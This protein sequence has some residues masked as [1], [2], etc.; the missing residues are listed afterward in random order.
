MRPGQL[1]RVYALPTPTGSKHYGPTIPGS[2]TASVRRYSCGDVVNRRAGGW[3]APG[4]IKHRQPSMG[5]SATLIDAHT[6][7][8]IWKSDTPA[9]GAEPGDFHRRT[10][11]RCLAVD[12]D[13][14][15]AICRSEFFKGAVVSAP[16][17]DLQTAP[18]K[19]AVFF[20][21]VWPPELQ[22]GRRI[23]P[24]LEA[25]GENLV[26]AATTGATAAAVFSAL[27]NGSRLRIPEL[28]WS[29]I[30]TGVTATP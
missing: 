30:G 10:V 21:I 20:L 6:G 4:F 22:L 18:S 29:T 13:C 16:A 14:P 1:G 11:R 8:R 28:R 26:P 23:Q 12:C 27:G 15:Q 3:K 24:D 7:Q 9:G 2:S 17:L 5:F 25:A 19:L